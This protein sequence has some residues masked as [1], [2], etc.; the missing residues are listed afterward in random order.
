MKKLQI[1]VVY[2]KDGAEPSPRVPGKDIE[3]LM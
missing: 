2:F 3:E 1:L